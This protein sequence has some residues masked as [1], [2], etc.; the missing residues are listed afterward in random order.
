MELADIDDIDLTDAA[1]YVDAVPHEWFAALRRQAPVWWHEETSAPASGASPSTTTASPSTARHF[2]SARKATFSGMALS[3]IE[4][5]ATDDAEHGPAHAHPLPATGQ[6]GLRPQD[7]PG[8]P[9]TDTRFTDRIIDAVCEKGTADFVEEIS[10]ELPLLVIAELLGIPPED[11]RLV[12][13]WSNRM[14]GSEDPEYQ[15]SPPKPGT[16]R[17]PST[18]TPTSLLGEKG[19]PPSADMVSVLLEAEVEDEK[20]TSWSST[21]SSCCWWWPAT[22]PP[23]T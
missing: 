1:N 6:Q 19:W 5:A 20:L 15:L 4:P 17:W 18:P 8:P 10:A 12:F 13:D 9:A 16:R 21:C 11:R 14:V 3:A 7:G 23:G 22:R 2:S